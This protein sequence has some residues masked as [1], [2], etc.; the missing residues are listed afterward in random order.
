MK[1]IIEFKDIRAV[2]ELEAKITEKANSYKALKVIQEKEY[3]TKV[4]NFTRLHR[5]GNDNNDFTPQPA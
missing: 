2:L 1:N 3:P 4:W 5:N